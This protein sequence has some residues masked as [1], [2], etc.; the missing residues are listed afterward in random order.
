MY[1]YQPLSLAAA[2]ALA[3]CGAMAIPS[4]NAATDYTG[5]SLTLTPASDE[6]SMLLNWIPATDE[7]GPAP[8]CSA[9]PYSLYLFVDNTLVLNLNEQNS[10][11]LGSGRSCYLQKTILPGAVYATTISPGVWTASAYNPVGIWIDETRTIYA[12]TAKQGK[13]PMYWTR[14]IAYTDNFYTTSLNDRNTSLQIGYSNYG[15]PFALPSQVRFGSAPFYRYFKGAP[16]SEHFYTSSTS[17]GQFLQQNGYSYEGI[18]GHIFGEYKPGSVG[19]FRYSLH[20]SSNN[21]LQ[22]LYT[23]NRYDYYASGMTFDG[24]IGYVCPM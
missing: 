16:Q 20:N 24:L 15:V 10:P 14:N 1:R 7:F 23:T 22:H 11:L 13:K 2:G 5:Q 6:S 9:K 18:E 19:L 8:P 17:E 4:A 12:C 21:D 3:L